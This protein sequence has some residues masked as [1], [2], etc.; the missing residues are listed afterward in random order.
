MSYPSAA[1]R[2]SIWISARVTVKHGLNTCQNWKS[3]TSVL[4]V[5]GG[6]DVFRL[7]SF[8]TKFT[9]KLVLLI[10]REQ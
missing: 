10:G 4:C 6:F 8:S 1:S 2:V 9:L 3:E 7:K 5:D